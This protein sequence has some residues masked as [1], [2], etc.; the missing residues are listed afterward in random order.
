MDR[1]VTSLSWMAGWL[2]LAA[3]GCT[4]AQYARQADQTAYATIVSTQHLALAASRPFDVTYRPVA[5]AASRPA[6]PI[7][8]GG[9]TVNL[10][11]DQPAVLT[12]GECLEIAFRNSRTLQTRKEQLY[13]QALALANQRRSWDS[14][15][16]AGALPAALEHAEVNKG[17]ETDAAAAGPNASLTQQFVNGGAL[18]LGAALNLATDLSGINNTL[19]GSLLSA[20]FT[21]PLLQGAWRGFAYEPQYRRERDFV[22]A[23]FDHERFTQTFAT[24]ILTDY[25]HV[26]EQRDQLENEAANIDRLKQTLAL[27]KVLAEGGQV[28]RIQQDQAEQNL[29]DAQV[30][31]EGSRQGYRDALDQFKVTLGLPI[32]ANVEPDY[33]AVLKALAEGGPRSIDLDEARAISVALS[34]RPDVLTQRAGVRDAK[35]DVEI[36]ADMFYPEVDLAVGISAANTGRNDFARTRFD[37]HSRYASLAVDYDL[38]QT[39]N[40]DAYRTAILAHAKAQRDLAEFEDRV[41]MEVRSAYRSLVQSRKSYELQVH[42]VEIAL[43][44][45]KLAALQ[46]KEG[47]ASAR[48]VLEAEEALR[49]AQNGL[50][51]A[52]VGYTATRLGFLARLGMLEVDERGQVH[53]RAEPV[54]FD[55]IERRYDYV[56]A[57]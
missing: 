30:R 20:N 41:R 56:G 24:G 57:R 8:I 44:R 54:R 1:R 42:N 48:D 46:Q 12:A 40:R 43:R 3:G 33:P 18:T 51:R 7:R 16:L 49:T 23:V 2:L 53:E 28:S 35:R 27:T 13:S 55:R 32:M 45:R 50:T 22:F 38:D 19:A 29:L 47:L 11:G 21:Q 14:P 9:R 5:Q 10:A 37:R 34:S 17:D 15:L 52:L 26:L 6:D 31:I 36:A 39:D 4:P 25:Y